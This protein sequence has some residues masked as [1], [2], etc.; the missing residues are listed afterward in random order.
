MVRHLLL[1]ILSDSIHN[2]S[3]DVKV[4]KYKIEQMPKLRYPGQL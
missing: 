4:T 3:N 2:S 1:Y